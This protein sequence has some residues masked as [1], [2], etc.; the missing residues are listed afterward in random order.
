MGRLAW[1]RGV[2]WDV[3]SSRGEGSG[4]LL[5]LLAWM[6]R[7]GPVLRQHGLALHVGLSPKGQVVRRHWV[8]ATSWH[9]LH[10]L[11]GALL[12]GSPT[13]THWTHLV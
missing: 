6:G 5:L 1:H 4:R 9:L 3:L 12:H 10:G 7:L 8:P 11:H 13:G 2:A